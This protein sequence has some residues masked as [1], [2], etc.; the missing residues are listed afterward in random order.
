MLNWDQWW[1]KIRIL[2]WI[3]ILALFVLQET[4]CDSLLNDCLKVNDND[5]EWWTVCSIYSIRFKLCCLHCKNILIVCQESDWTYMPFTLLMDTIQ[6]QVL[7]CGSSKD[8]FFFYFFLEC[9]LCHFLSSL[10]STLSTLNGTVLICCR[11][12]LLYKYTTFISISISLLKT[13]ETKHERVT[14]SR[15]K[16]KSLNWIDFYCNMRNMSIDSV[17]MHTWKWIFIIHCPLAWRQKQ[18]THRISIRIKSGLYQNDDITHRI[19]YTYRTTTVHNNTNIE[20]Q[21]QQLIAG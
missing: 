9:P 13:R 10:Q 19:H 16:V 18:N 3:K 8:A 15:K 1:H 21:Q 12:T 2:S 5:S 20:R 11:I 4:C 14:M 6:Y 17:G 7:E